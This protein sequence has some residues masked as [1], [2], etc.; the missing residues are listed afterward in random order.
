MRGITAM[1]LVLGVVVL[2]V[3]MADSQRNF[4]PPDD[5]DYLVI[6]FK[7][8]RQQR[9]EM[10]DIARMEFK[11]SGF[12]GGRA[13]FLGRWRVG[14]GT[15]ETFFITLTPDGQATRNNGNGRGTW[16]VANR[17]ARI[18]W[19]DGWHDVIRRV[20]NGYEKAAFSPGRPLDGRPSNVTEAVNTE[21]RPY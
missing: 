14:S 7:D 17:E 10:S 1:I 13:K 18:T 20:G 5:D 16:T 4:G 15:G 19:D 12:A 9:L 3:P 6:I 2:A 8:G 21:P 11:S